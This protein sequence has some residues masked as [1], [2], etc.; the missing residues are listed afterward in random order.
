MYLKCLKL[1][2]S[3]SRCSINICEINEDR[4]EFSGNKKV[5]EMR[6][7]DNDVKENYFRIGALSDA[8]DHGDES[9]AWQCVRP[10]EGEWTREMGWKEGEIETK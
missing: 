8:A 10:V 5:E 6:S 1:C 4:I 7:Q 3:N 2:L 9:K